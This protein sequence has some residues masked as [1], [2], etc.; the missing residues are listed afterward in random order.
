MHLFAANTVEGR[1]L[2]KARRKA[3][4][5]G[6]ALLVTV[7]LLSF[8]VL[9]LVALAT[10]TRVE[11]QVA[12]NTQ[13]LDAARNHA[14]L[15]LNVALGQLQA[16]SGPDY[17][18]TTQANLLDANSANPWFTGVWTADTSATPT[19]RSWLV[20]GNETV[21]LSIT[22]DSALGRTNADPE[23]ALTIGSDGLAS[24]GPET[25]NPNRVQL[26]G[27]GSA[28]TTGSAMANGS[29]VVPGVPINAPVSGFSSDRTVGRYAWWVGDQGVKA[30][31]ALPDRAN[32]VTYAPWNTQAQR[33][34]IRQQLASTP[35][36]FRENSAETTAALEGFDPLNT[37]YPLQNILSQDQLSLQPPR[38]GVMADFLRRH[39]FEFTTAN[40]G[41]LAN[42]RSDSHAGLMR[43]LSLKPEE[44][45]TAYATYANYSS[46]MEPPGST[47]SGADA[48]YPAIIDADSPRR[49]YK[50]V[51]P[52][53]S[54]SV[55]LPDVEF[56]I[57]PVINEFFLHFRVFHS[58][59]NKMTMRV[60]LY[61]SLWNPY[62]S[63]LAP[64]STDDLS[65]EITGLPTVTVK[66]ETSAASTVIKLQDDLPSFIKNSDGALTVKLPFGNAAAT[67]G[68]QAD[69]SSW[70][71][72]RVYGWVTKSGVGL[73]DNTLDFYTKTLNVT[74]WSYPEVD[75]S[76]STSTPLAVTTNGTNVNGITVTLKS[77]AGVLATY[78]L[79]EFKAIDAAGVSGTNGTWRFGFATSLKQ[80]LYG[81]S[82]RT[83][84][85]KT[86]PRSS[87]LPP[88]SF[89]PFEVTTDTAEL[90]PNQY[91]T[92]N[93]AP[94]S[95]PEFLLYRP[96]AVAS[97]G[98]SQ[99]SYNDVPIFELPR[100]PLL[101]AGGLQHL[102]LKG[103][104]P[105]AIGNSWGEKANAIF[106]RYFFS[107]LPPTA[108]TSFHDPDLTSGQPLPNWNLRALNHTTSSQ[109][110]D[111]GALS[112]KYLLQGGAFNVNSTSA[113]AWRAVLSA[114]RFGQAFA[115][116]DIENS[117][118][119]AYGTQKTSSALGG[120]TF[121][122][123]DTLG[124]GTAAPVFFHFPQSAQET[125]FWKPATGG[126]STPRQLSSFAFRLG[127][128]GN[129]DTT[130]TTATV[131]NSVTELALSTDQIESLAE[132]IVRLI[133]LHGPFPSLEAF[134]G[135]LGASGTDS[136]LETAIANTNINEDAVKPL[137][138]VA[139]Y[140]SGEYGAGL[141]SLTL[142]QA[143]LLGALAPYLR[144]RSDTFTIR[145]YGESIDTLTGEVDGRAWCE[146]T[147]QRF[148][149]TVDST[150]SIA[151]PKGPL[152]RRYKLTSFRWLSPNDI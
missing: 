73:T 121:N 120:T 107:G 87:T 125:F 122:A 15:A 113:A 123:D 48:A 72:G 111:E 110:R 46:Y 21:P 19:V 9:I 13:K 138:F 137:D 28:T 42:T 128:R 143:N 78:T 92:A 115:P 41:V 63:A 27:P 106:D 109:L 69:R 47:L 75:L 150:D 18:L 139:Q 37:S 1:Q 93:S 5:N 112:S 14:L 10:L 44:L 81:D 3:E 55:D 94:T 12:T 96:M 20:S 80:P 82:D 141:S 127:V 32:E 126:V 11:T 45:G 76:G 103:M 38:S 148:P 102:Q 4:R 84:L 105:F 56:G 66:D 67:R 40:Y 25:A 98:A 64:T 145:T 29:V 65:L 86:D 108:T 144:T 53:S 71:P 130:L 77:S 104:R 52:T 89:G 131:D 85:K 30:S 149:E 124:K 79:P 147:V 152:G 129:D 90:D 34:R 99:S 119:Q 62:T 57:A 95:H 43:D 7:V 36:Y 101:S 88:A 51:T 16:Q 136:L 26:V 83:W 100:M 117:S 118:G 135:P 2:T 142:T 114:V 49:R 54:T 60:R 68:T 59:A 6:F 58:A 39:Y 17:R 151:Q 146:A 74:G 50:L 132:E 61:V 22:P 97:D 31:L 70:L 140:P 116:A 24:N 23:I 91:T 134:L 35:N 8:L 33:N 133:R